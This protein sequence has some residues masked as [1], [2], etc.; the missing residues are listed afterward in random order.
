[1]LAVEG[2]RVANADAERVGQ[3]HLEH[4]LV[5]GREPAAGHQQRPVDHHRLPL[6]QAHERHQQGGAMDLEGGVAALD[7]HADGLD[8]GQGGQRPRVR[9][10]GGLVD[11]DV[12]AVGRRHQ[13][14]P[15]VVGH[16]EH[17]QGAERDAGSDRDHHHQH[18][19]P[20][21]VRPQPGQHQGCL[22]HL[23]TSPVSARS[24]P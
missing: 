9:S 10:R 18:Q 15:R 16:P 21:Q 4:H 5:V 19:R 12:R 8:L 11:L 14:R 22:K 1:V 13:G 20:P 2:D 24:G 7:Q 17:G 6:R 23:A 3:G